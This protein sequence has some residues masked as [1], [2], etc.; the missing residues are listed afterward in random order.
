MAREEA[1]LPD[2]VR[3]TDHISLGVLAKHFPR[4]VVERV[5]RDTG[6]A[7]QRQ[8]DLP[9]H[10]VVYY[11][12]ALAL[13]MQ[14]SYREVMRCLLEGLQWLSGLEHRLHVAGKSGISQARKRIGSEPLLRLHDEVVRPVAV[15]NDQQTTRGAFYRSWRLVAIDGSTLDVADTSANTAAFG[16]PK[17]GR[18][19]GGFPQ[20]R[21]VSLVESGTHVLFASR[22]A[23][24]QVSEI[25]LSKEVFGALQPGMLCLADR[26]YF[27]YPQWQQ[28]SATGAELLWRLKCNRILPCLQRFDDGSYLSRI[29]PSQTDRCQDR[30]GVAVRIIEYALD[31]QPDA[32]PFYR[33]ATT[34]LDPQQSPAE[35]LALLYPQRW[36]IEG[37]FDELK[38]HLRGARIILRSKSPELVKQEFYG[39]MMA[40]YA[41]RALMHEAALLS[42]VDPDRLSYLHTVRIIRRKMT[43]CAAFPPSGSGAGQNGSA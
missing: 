3:I 16:R 14:V 15:R 29:Y 24:Y 6:R 10:V 27:G 35:E 11:V 40:H 31:N 1:L 12:I 41:I 21:F 25:A 20:I 17:N 30:N 19:E 42:E 36:E 2:G 39:L 13:Y 33:L 34:L 26:V 32:E 23:G 9:G 37:A 7:S 18:G 38:T 43:V 4:D 22:M 28:A 8:R 5:L